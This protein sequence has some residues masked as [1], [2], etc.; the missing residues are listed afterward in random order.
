MTDKIPMCWKCDYKIAECDG[1]GFGHGH[2]LVGCK[3]CKDIHNYEDAKELCPVLK[4]MELN[5]GETN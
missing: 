4:E 5:D 3:E 1:E 2:V